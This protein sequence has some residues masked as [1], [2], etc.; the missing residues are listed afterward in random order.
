MH[1][2]FQWQNYA[3]NLKHALIPVLICICIFSIQSVAAENEQ[4]TL[5]LTRLP[6]ASKI[7]IDFPRDIQ[8]LFSDK[9]VKCHGAEK[10]KGG[11]RLDSKAAAF[12]GGDDGKV[13]VP[14]KSS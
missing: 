9:C 2:P 7:L 6:P 13:I 10:Q 8:P 11:L 12:K 3:L 4:K 1:C 5:D 14:G